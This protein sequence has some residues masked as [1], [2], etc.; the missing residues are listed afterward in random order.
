MSSAAELWAEF[1]ASTGVVAVYEA[2]GFGTS[3][4]PTLRDE[5][6]LLVKNGVKTAT[7]AHP[8]E[9][10][11]AGEKIPQVGDYWVVLDS[12]DNAHAVIRTTEVMRTCFEEVDS[13]FAYDEGEGDRTLS[14]WRGA[15]IEYFREIGLFLDEKTMLHLERFVKVWPI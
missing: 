4:T 14:W 8:E 7:A 5:L 11:I 10:E 13:Q 3:G 12:K 2:F 1:S 15:H 9:F 6:A